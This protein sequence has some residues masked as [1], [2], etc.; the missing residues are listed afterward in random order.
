MMPG[1]ESMEPEHNESPLAFVRVIHSMM[2]GRY[3]WA[4]ALG[5]LGGIL[6]S[7]AGYF[8]APEREYTSTGLIQFHP[9]LPKTL[10][11]TDINQMLPTFGSYV[12]SQVELMRDRRVID[13]AM[14]DERW[15]AL[16]REH[17]EQAVLDF[18]RS[19]RIVVMG[20]GELVQVRFTDPEATAASAAVASVIDAYWKLYG[21][22]DTKV[23]DDRLVFLE[24]RRTTLENNLKTLQEKIHDAAAKYGTAS[25]ESQFAFQVSE[26]QKVESEINDVDLRLAQMPKPPPAQE[27]EGE[28]VPDG[29][30][31]TAQTVAAAQPA[32]LDPSLWTEEQI[33]L[34]DERMAELLKTGIALRA[35]IEQ[36]LLSLGE[37]HREMIRM[38]TAQEQNAR[39]IE[40]RAQEFRQTYK[41]GGPALMADSGVMSREQLTVKRDQLKAMAAQLETEVRDIGGVMLIIERYREEASMVEARLRE[42]DSR[43]EM[44]TVES[45]ARRDEDAQVAGRLQIRSKGDYPLPTE[46]QRARMATMGG[47][48]GMGLGIGII[49][50]VGFRDPRCHAPEDARN[51]IGRANMLGVLPELPH[52][53][54]DADQASLAAHAVHQIRTTLQ[55]AIGRH[56]ASVLAITSAAAQD[57]KTSLTMALG[58]SF[59]HTGVRTL[60]IDC[61]MATGTLSRR[62]RAI[63]RR[64]I[65][66]VLLREG[67]ITPEQLS[68][69]LMIASNTSRP[70]GEVL[71]ALQY[72]TSEQ[73]SRALTIQEAS[74]LGLTEML[75]G[76]R[77]EACVSNTGTPNLDVLPVGAGG[78]EQAGRFSPEKL[79][80]VLQQA[81]EHYDLVLIDTGPVLGSLESAMVAAEV[82][83]TVLVVSRGAPRPLVRRAVE[84][85]RELHAQLAGVVFN[86]AETREFARYSALASTTSRYQELPREAE[87]DPAAADH[88]RFGPVV[89]AVKTAPKAVYAGAGK[90]QNN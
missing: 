21:E 24:A 78:A 58:L 89:G 38:R 71:V 52:D 51:D 83:A 11:E 85:L 20:G 57:G 90:G 9:V 68:E 36:A 59:A 84:R 34:Q 31:E 55:I 2:R 5:L 25:L 72:L 63:V 50:L 12:A 8:A 70:L 10:Y 56:D 35:G 47:I 41:A 87:K 80:M 39:Q 29:E 30:G 4:I 16:N 45:R 62:A 74:S 69:A 79:R 65:G 81:R 1:P 32:E 44:L 26:L 76:E 48:A 14:S 82:D 7:T 46:D 17:S 6:G 42:T 67:L 27:G 49:A 73:V 75:V 64:K 40:E 43:I 15:K 88:R 61:D 60:L 66:Q 23:Q 86:R 19:L 22:V 28:A 37:N 53:L 18:M 54:A 77:L 33:A 13:L 3:H